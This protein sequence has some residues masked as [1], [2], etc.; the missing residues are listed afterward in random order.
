MSDEE[1]IVLLA[2]AYELENLN[3]DKGKDLTDYEKIVKQIGDTVARNWN[4]PL[5]I[6]Y[7]NKTEKST[8]NEDFITFAIAPYFK[9][10]EDGINI[11]LIG[12]KIS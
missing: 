8:G 12:K 11:S 3:K 1:A 7:G 6:F 2:Q 4:I 9:I 5:D 10:L